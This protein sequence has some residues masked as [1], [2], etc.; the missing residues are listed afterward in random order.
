MGSHG[1]FLCRGPVHKALGKGAF[2]E[3]HSGTQQSLC[4]R[5]LAPWRRL[6]FCRVPDKKY[7]TKKSL[8][9]C[10]SPRLLCRVSHS[11]KD[12]VGCFPGFAKWFRH[13]T[14]Q[15]CPV[16]FPNLVVI[17]LQGYNHRHNHVV[18]QT[19]SYCVPWLSSWSS[20]GL[21]TTRTQ[22]AS[23]QQRTNI[24]S[25]FSSFTW[26]NHQLCQQRNN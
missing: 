15:L 5:H 23:L 26:P 17:T 3:C 1:V 9:I 25:V 10:S 16:V 12:F 21:S 11:S 20:A 24:T 18:E 8:P 14:K 22:T 13:S 7:S 2:A 4:H 19:F 6:F